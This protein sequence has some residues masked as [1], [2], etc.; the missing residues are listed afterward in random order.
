MNEKD[1]LKQ[2]IITSVLSGSKLVREALKNNNDIL[3]SEKYPTG[4]YNIDGDIYIR[5]NKEDIKEDTINDL[6]NI[7]LGSEVT[8]KEDIEPEKEISNA[9]LNAKKDLLEFDRNED[10][11][12]KEFKSIYKSKSS[13]E[14]EEEIEEDLEESGYGYS[15]ELHKICEPESNK[16]DITIE[17]ELNGD[18][19][20]EVNNEDLINKDLYKRLDFKKLNKLKNKLLRSFKGYS[21][22]I[23]SYSPSKKFNLKKDIVDKDNIYYKNKS[24]DGNKIYINFIIDMSGSMSGEPIENAVSI[25]WLFNELSKE[26]Y[27]KG[28]ILYSYGG[29]FTHKSFPMKDEE[30]LY[31][32]SA[33]SGSEGIAN[34][35]EKNKELLRNSHTICITDGRITDKPIKHSY[36]NRLRIQSTGIYV[37]PDVKDIDRLNRYKQNLLKYFHNGIVR[38]NLDELINWLVKFKIK[39]K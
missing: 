12:I 36:W 32:S 34:T 21:G 31:V 13:S 2:Q 9:Y 22:K 4:K 26:G 3:Y 10:E 28:N 6:F 37:N 18:T 25:L 8:N 16:E 38:S 11:L 35:V 19:E 14:T 20:P 29:G 39:E 15:K 27:I 17:P 7:L 33:F 5:I 1:I 24:F 23:S 30:V